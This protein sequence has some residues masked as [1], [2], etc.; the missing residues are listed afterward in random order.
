[1]DQELIPDAFMTT[2]MKRFTLSKDAWAK[3][4]ALAKEEIKFAKGGIHQ[5]IDKDATKREQDGRPILTIN[6]IPQFIRQ[7]TNDQRQNRSGIKV[8]PTDSTVLL[9]GESGTGKEVMANTIHRLSP[10]R[11]QAFVAINCAA[12][13]E[14]L[15]ESELFGHVKGAFTSAESDKVGLFEEADNGTIF[16][17][18]I[19]DLPLAAQAKLLRVLQNGEIRRVGDA[20]TRHVDVRILAA[21][22]RNL[23]EAV[24]NNQFREDVYFRLNVI[25]ILIPPLRERRDAIPA[26]VREF[27]RR[28]SARFHRNVHTIDEHAWSLL[29][30]YRYPG[31][32]RE[33]ESTVAHAVILADGDTIHVE[34]LPDSIRFGDGASLALP[35]YDSGQ[36][37]T[38]VDMEKDLIRTALEKLNGNQT[39][40]AKKL[41]VSRSTLWRKMKEYGLSRKA[42]SEEV[43]ES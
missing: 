37:P 34:N 9:L 2:A 12:L 20:Q 41:G 30:H 25:Q 40:V 17:D 16:L 43:V 35:H 14:Q 23:V 33:L 32:I 38:L 31:N 21:T 5:W 7:V 1:M 24:A 10:R 19:G 26:L 29:Q 39:E 3:R 22:N 36:I 18:E 11:D 15:L 42:S 13:P 8:A 27:L 4:R 28:Y 6:R